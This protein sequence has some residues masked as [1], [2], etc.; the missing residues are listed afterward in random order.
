MRMLYRLDW[1]IYG[2]SRARILERVI[3]SKY[4]AFARI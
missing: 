4:E 3:D 2:S 1:I